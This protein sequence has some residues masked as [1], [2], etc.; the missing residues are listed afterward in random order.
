ALPEYQ[1]VKAE[2]ARTRPAIQA[3]RSPQYPGT[4][5]RGAGRPSYGS[6]GLRCGTS[7]SGVCMERSMGKF[8]VWRAGTGAGRGGRIDGQFQDR[9]GAG[10]SRVRRVHGDRRGG[11]RRVPVQRVRLRRHGLARAAALPHVRG[12]VVGTVRV[13]AVH[14]RA[15]APVTIGRVYRP[16]RRWI[17]CQVP[18]TNAIARMSSTAITM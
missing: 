6:T 2:I 4:A 18:T 7:G 1:S 11:L 13:A 16:T 14:A 9:Y 3:R 8:P 17:S 15:A 5:G 12:D 10:G